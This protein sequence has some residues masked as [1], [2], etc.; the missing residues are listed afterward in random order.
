MNHS[1]DSSQN[2]TAARDVILTNSNANLRE[3]SGNINNLIEQLPE[4]K[5]DETPSIKELLSQ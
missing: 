1:S 5:S 4:Q 3:T 2:I